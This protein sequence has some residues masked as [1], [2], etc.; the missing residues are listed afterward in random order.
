MNAKGLKKVDNYMKK[1]QDIA[2]WRKFSSADD[3]EYMEC[4]MEMEQEMLKSYVVVERIVDRQMPDSGSEYPDYYVK[5]RNLPYSEA[6]WES[7]KLIEEENQ[8]QIRQY[9][10]REESGKL[11]E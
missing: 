6:T 1:Q 10:I 9:R 2:R 5:W 3:V 8:E 7:G 4:Q 11:I